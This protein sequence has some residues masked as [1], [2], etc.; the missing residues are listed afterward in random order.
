MFL[1]LPL[2]D[3]LIVFRFVLNLIVLELALVCIY[4]KEKCF[5][6]MWLFFYFLPVYIQRLDENSPCILTC[7]L[8]LIQIIG[9]TGL[10]KVTL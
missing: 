2:F 8:I 4:N 1:V 6:F 9:L 10:Y 5:S 3:F 7:R